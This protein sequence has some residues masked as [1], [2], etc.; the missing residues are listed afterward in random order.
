MLFC[1]VPWYGQSSIMVKG[2]LNIVNSQHEVHWYRGG[3]QDWKAIRSGG[4]VPA[5]TRHL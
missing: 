5:A 3:M 4:G 1:N 2:L